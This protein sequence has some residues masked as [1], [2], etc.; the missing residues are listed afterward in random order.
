MVLSW[1]GTYH[2]EK[3]MSGLRLSRTSGL[4][5]MLTR[6]ISCIL[7]HGINDV[8]QLPTGTAIKI[9]TFFLLFNSFLASCDLSS[10]DNLCKQF[11]PKSIKYKVY[12]H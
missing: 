10:A 2:S 12:W 6:S 1:T 9:Q 5:P 8:C 4:Q 11:G 3:Q 7:K